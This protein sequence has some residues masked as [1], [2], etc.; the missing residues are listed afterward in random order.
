MTET[1]DPRP[2]IFKIK[3]AQD[4]IWSP[5]KIFWVFRGNGRHRMG[6]IVAGE[7]RTDVLRIWPFCHA[8]TKDDLKGL[9]SK[10]A[11]YEWK[12]RVIEHARRFAPDSPEARPDRP[13]DPRQIP[14]LF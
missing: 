11:W 3:L 13:V 5:V 6:A 1:F 8:V 10:E 4:A 12:V 7:W 2:G 14:R 9:G